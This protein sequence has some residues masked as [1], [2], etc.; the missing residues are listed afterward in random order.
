M[1][2]DTHK[3]YGSNAG[4]SNMGKREYEGFYLNKKDWRSHII[5]KLYKYIIYINK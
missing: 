5:Y 3:S 2:F 1:Q 4:S